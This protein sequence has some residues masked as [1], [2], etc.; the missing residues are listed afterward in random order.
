MKKIFKAYYRLLLNELGGLSSDMKDIAIKR[1]AI[2]K[3][4]EFGKGRITCKERSCICPIK[5]KC[6]DFKATC[7][8]GYWKDVKNISIEK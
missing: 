1:Y 5:A 6:M 4:C 7:P 3:E 2:C 8:R